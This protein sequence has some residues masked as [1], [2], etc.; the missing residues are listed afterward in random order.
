MHGLTALKALLWLCL[1]AIE[2]IQQVKIVSGNAETQVQ[3]NL[4]ED[5]SVSGNSLDAMNT[6]FQTVAPSDLQL[7]SK[8]YEAYSE[9]QVS[10]IGGLRNNNQIT[11]FL[12]RNGQ[13]KTLEVVTDATGFVKMQESFIADLTNATSGGKLYPNCSNLVISLDRVFI[14]CKEMVSG[15]SSSAIL[16]IFSF[17]KLDFSQSSQHKLEVSAFTYQTTVDRPLEGVVCSFKSGSEIIEYLAV[18]ETPTKEHPSSTSLIFFYTLKDH[19]LKPGSVNI[20]NQLASFSRLLTFGCNANPVDNNRYL[21]LTSTDT[22]NTYI[23][24]ITDNL[25]VQLFNDQKFVPV[26]K[27]TQYTLGN[28]VIVHSTLSMGSTS[29]VLVLYADPKAQTYRLA[30][31]QLLFVSLDVATMNSKFLA[32]LDGTTNIELFP[33]VKSSF[34]IDA[35]AYRF[36]QIVNS[37]LFSIEYRPTT[38]SK[39]PIIVEILTNQNNIGTYVASRKIPLRTGNY[40]VTPR[41]SSSPVMNEPEYLISS[42][43]VDPSSLAPSSKFVCTITAFSLS[44]TNFDLSAASL[45]NGTTFLS[46]CC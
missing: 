31:T 45:K 22:T 6:L 39:D 40:I 2:T 8:K 46:K 29:Q 15:S 37:M 16:K 24:P 30:R 26:T 1:C 32:D 28:G 9:T 12:M 17:L 7:N 4:L 27:P 41:S 10:F 5:L 19:K 38:Q 35:S 43:T 11:Y 18:Y 36:R 21:F 3:L 34:V 42:Q 23:V 33:A 13:L 44:N 20:L 25:L 14:L